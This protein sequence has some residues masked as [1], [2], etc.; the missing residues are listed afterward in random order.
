MPDHARD[1]D[2]RV[3]NEHYDALAAGGGESLSDRL[4]AAFR[5]AGLDPG[6]LTLDEIA[7]IDQ[8][9]LG[10]RAASRSLARLCLL[11]TSPSPRD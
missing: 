7:G 9:H 8:L 5:E 1:H 4:Q 2:A 3:L 10:G 6:R 11:Y